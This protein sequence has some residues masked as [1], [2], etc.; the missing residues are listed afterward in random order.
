MTDTDAAEQ[1]RRRREQILREARF[2]ARRS[3][4]SASADDGLPSCPSAE[5]AVVKTIVSEDSHDL[6]AA[7]VPSRMQREIAELEAADRERAAETER[8]HQ[9]E[10]EHRQ[11]SDELTKLTALRNDVVEVSKA[12]NTFAEAI[13]SRVEQQDAALD[14]L[15]NRVSELEQRKRTTKAKRSDLPAFLPAR[16]S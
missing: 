5:A 9:F 2:N 4:A 15:R 13:L 11:R 1:A 12:M 14:A 8:R 10:R 7:A 16:L 6:L 3:D